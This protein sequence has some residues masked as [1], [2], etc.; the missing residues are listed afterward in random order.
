NIAIQPLIKVFGLR[1]L[2][3]AGFREQL[4][5]LF[6]SSVKASFLSSLQGTSLNASASILLVVAIAGGTVLAERGHL[7][8]GGLVAVIDPLWVMVASLAALAQGL[9][10]PH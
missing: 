8:V 10:R 6:R 4:G 5:V 9:H 3:L 1:Q 2:A 7:S